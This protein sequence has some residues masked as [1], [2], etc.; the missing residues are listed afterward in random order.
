MQSSNPNTSISLPQ[1][2]RASGTASERPGAER[3]GLIPGT[4]RCVPTSMFSTAHAH[5]QVQ[6]QSPPHQGCVG[7]ARHHWES[8]DG[9]ERFSGST[10][11]A[12]ACNACLCLKQSISGRRRISVEIQTAPTKLPHGLLHVALRHSTRTANGLLAMVLVPDS[13]RCTYRKDKG[14]SA[15]R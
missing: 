12:I 13:T 3:N 11:R 7:H 1:I 9:R 5:L 15:Q 10:E 4:I 14:S 6:P 2:Y 8:S